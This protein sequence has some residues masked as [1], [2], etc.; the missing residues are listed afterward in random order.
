M[1]LVLIVSRAGVRCS[2]LSTG[3]FLPSTDFSTVS[4]NCGNDVDYDYI[5]KHKLKCTKCRE[6][7]S[8]IWIKKR[9]TKP[10]MAKTVIAR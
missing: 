7:R 5:V 3:S 6:K 2:P 8:N 9:P 10:S 1:I 4:I